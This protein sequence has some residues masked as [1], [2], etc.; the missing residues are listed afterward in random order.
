MMFEDVGFEHDSR[1]ALKT[2]GV[3]TPHLK[4]I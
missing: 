1:S 4:L 3:G 2:E